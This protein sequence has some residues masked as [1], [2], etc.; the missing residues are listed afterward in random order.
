MDTRRNAAN[1]EKGR[2]Q[3]MKGAK[4]QSSKQQGQ[5]NLQRKHL[6]QTDTRRKAAHQSVAC[7]QANQSAK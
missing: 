4:C 3:S 1:M 6:K 5:C 2:Q 7:V